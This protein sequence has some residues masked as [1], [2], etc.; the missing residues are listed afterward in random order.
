MEHSLKGIVHPKM[1]IL[2]LFTH[3]QVVPHLYEFFSSAEH[4]KRI[5]WRML[6]TK[7]LVVAIGFHSTFSIYGSQ[8]LA[9]SSEYLLLC[10]ARKKETHTGLKQPEGEYDDRILNFVWNIPLTYFLMFKLPRIVFLKH[11]KHWM[12][13]T[14]REHL[15]NVNTY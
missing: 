8:W 6:L 3:P 9:Y 12:F 5:F 15:E 14:F 7:Q 10:S 4:K 1:N 11:L 13:W 2:S